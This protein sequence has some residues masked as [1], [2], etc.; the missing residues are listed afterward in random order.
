MK[1]ILMKF[2]GPAALALAIALN[3]CNNAEQTKKQTEEQNNQIQTQVDERLN[4]LQQQVDMECTAMVDSMATARYDEWF[5]TEGKK[6]G[7]K[8]A[9]KPKAKVTKTETKTETIGTGKPKMG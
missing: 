7:A 9:P 1:K 4:A 5:A 2:S 3:S 8:A 6:K